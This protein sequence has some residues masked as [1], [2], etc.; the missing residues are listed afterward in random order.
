MQGLI[1]FAHGA[2][3]ARWAEPFEQVA[4]RV[5]ALRPGVAV[6]LA[7][8]ELMAPDLDAAGAALARSGCREVAVLPL[9]LGAG[10]HVRKDLPERLERLRAAHPEV[11]WALQAAAGESPR[12]VE[13]LAQVALDALENDEKDPA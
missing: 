10:G 5:R 1:L 13:A 7:Y 9:F 11:R 12:L 6:A 3:D 4:A 8:L 2:R